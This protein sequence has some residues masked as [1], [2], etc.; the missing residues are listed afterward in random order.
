MGLGLQALLHALAD[1]IAEGE[2]SAIRHRIADARPHF[3]ALH[4]AALGQSIQMFRNVRLARARQRDE[5]ADIAFTL[6]QHG[7]QLQAQG[8][9]QEPKP[10]SNQIQ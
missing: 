5:F 10:L 6:T 7:E 8:F 9:T 3:A 4:E 2:N 1:D